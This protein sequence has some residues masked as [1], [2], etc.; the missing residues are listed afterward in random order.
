MLGGLE[1]RFKDEF[2]DGETTGERIAENGGLWGRGDMSM[3]SPEGDEVGI[4]G[5]VVQAG[6]DW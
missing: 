4:G 2:F 5:V 1:Q 3:I 6:K